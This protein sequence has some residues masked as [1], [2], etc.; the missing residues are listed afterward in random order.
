MKRTKYP[1]HPDFKTWTNLNPPLNRTMLPM[2]QKLMGLLFDWEKSAQDLAVERKIIP[3]GDGASIRA[4]WYQ[5]KMGMLQASSHCDCRNFLK[6]ILFGWLIL[7]SY[8]LGMVFLQ[9]E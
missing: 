9:E 1:I 7:T 8:F 2:M 4:L 5:R 6:L 3:V